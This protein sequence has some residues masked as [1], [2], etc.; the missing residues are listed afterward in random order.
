MATSRPKNRSYL[1]RLWIRAVLLCS[2][3]AVLVILALTSGD[4]GR[5]IPVAASI[6]VAAVMLVMVR[7]HQKA[8]IAR[9]LQAA[10]PNASL[11]SFATSV[12]RIPHG[13]LFA[14]SNSATIL[15]LYGRV[16]DAEHALQSVSWDGL[17]PVVDAQRSAACAVIAYARGAINE[18]LDHAVT[19]AQLASLDMSVPGARTSEVAFRTYRN[20]GL[21]LSGRATDTT[22][23]ELRVALAKLPLV[24]QLLAAWGLAIIAKGNG[25][26]SEL[27][28]M[29]ALIKKQAPFFAPVIESTAG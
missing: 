27:R 7:R 10:D 26:M 13:S 12:R 16:T 22:A 5:A 21:A 18:G 11:Q 14:A 4:P 25:N 8:R 23:Q 19:A 2:F 6:G 20:L 9:M 3:V 1:L 17:P 15:A 24:G 28:A 29:Q